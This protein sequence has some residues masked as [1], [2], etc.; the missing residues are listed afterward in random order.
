[1]VFSAGSYAC[2]RLRLADGTPDGPITLRSEGNGRV[3]FTSDSSALTLGSHTTVDGIEFECSAEHPRGAAISVPAKEHVT[4]QNCRCFAFQVG[5]APPATRR[6]SITNCEM[7]YSG[8]YG[9]HI[10]GSGDGP[11][12][13]WDPADVCRDIEIR[14]CYLHDAGWNTAGTEG[15]GFTANGAVEH[16]TIENC[17]IDNNSGDGILYE[18]WGIHTTARY[19]IIRGSAIAAIWIDNASMSNFDNNYLEANNVAVWLS[20][21]E[22][23]NRYLTD[24]VTVRNNIIVHNDWAP[25]A[26]LDSSVYGK[27]IFLIT[28]NTR[29]T[30]FDN[31]TVAFNNC[32][33][34]IAVET[35][36]RRTN[37][38]TSGS[39][40]ISSGRTRARLR[41]L[42][43]SRS[44]S[45]TLPATCGTGHTPAIPRP[46]SEIPCSW[47]P[48]AGT[49]RA[50]ESRQ[51]QPPGIRACSCMRTPW[52]SGT[53]PPAPLRGGQVRHRSRRV[54]CYG[55]GTH[56]ARSGRV[57]VSGSA[58]QASVQGEAQALKSA[59]EH[60]RES[61]Q[62]G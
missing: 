34:V 58:L 10:G 44:T 36:R 49:R 43:A 53:V 14:N 40:T 33:H 61:I 20:G 11:K 15:Y 50:T 30:Y 16:L 31:N 18:D 62:I 2:S 59:V 19:N 38:T 5:L 4:I 27:V 47:I 37:S 12:G 6:L 1:M 22:S 45:S 35:V 60:S 8:A 52:T 42:P 46:G 25:F 28:S 41:Q 17:Q 13:H 23:S 55:Q 3:I 29:N 21:E 9:I 26:A 39:A 54:W 48:R 57:P 51:D 7:A 32:R 24:F 56:R